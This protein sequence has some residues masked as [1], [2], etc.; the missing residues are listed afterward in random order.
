MLQRNILLMS[1]KVP[2]LERQPVG[3]CPENVFLERKSVVEC[4]K[5]GGCLFLKWRCVTVYQKMISLEV[6]A[7]VMGVKT[8]QHD[9][10]LWLDDRQLAD[11]ETLRFRHLTEL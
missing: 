4:H 2:V 9:N 7:L 1:W 5:A 11:S 6:M 10:C 8:R 3:R